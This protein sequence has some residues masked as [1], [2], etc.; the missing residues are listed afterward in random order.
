VES[1]PAPCKE[2]SVI[3]VLLVVAAAV[4]NACLVLPVGN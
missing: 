2:Y 3:T 4:A 1:S